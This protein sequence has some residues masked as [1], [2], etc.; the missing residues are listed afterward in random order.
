MRLPDI[1]YNRGVEPLAKQDPNLPRKEAQV[2]IDLS[3]ARLG[4][5]LRSNDEVGAANVRLAKLRREVDREQINTYSNIAISAFNR[6]S[7]KKQAKEALTIGIA[8]QFVQLA[9]QQGAKWYEANE[10]AKVAEGITKYNSGVTNL[11]TKLENSPTISLEDFPG[12]DFSDVPENMIYHGVDAV[13]GKNIRTVPNHVAAPI[14]FASTE[15]SIREAAGEG[16]TGTVSKAQFT[17]GISNRSASAMASVVRS[18]YD[19][20][21]K[22]L[23]GKYKDSYDQAIQQEDIATASDIVDS[24]EA[25]GIWTAE[26]AGKLRS[27][28]LGDVKFSRLVR[29]AD[30]ATTLDQ[31]KAVREE[32][33]DMPKSEQISIRA[34]LSRREN[35]FDAAREKAETAAKR[36]ILA[37]NAELASDIGM[38]AKGGYSD[39]REEVRAWASKNDPENMAH[40]I[41]H[42]TA[43]FNQERNAESAM[44][45]EIT[46]QA[47][48]DIY[49]GRT[50]E[51]PPE[52]TGLNYIKLDELARMKKSGIAPV[53]D[54]KRWQELYT[55]AVRQPEK[56][57][58]LPLWAERGS[59]DSGSFEQLVKMQNSITD[60]TF[61]KTQTIAAKAQFDSMAKQAWGPRYSSSSSGIRK[62]SEVEQ[63]YVNAV[64]QFEDDNNRK[65]TS[66]ERQTILNDLFE[67][68]VKV[69]YKSTFSGI[70]EGDPEP[71]ISSDM[72]PYIRSISALLNARNVPVTSRNIAAQYNK[73]IKDGTLEEL[74]W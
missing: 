60:G 44:V 51:I 36:T 7:E 47:A 68:K 16:I 71:I 29:Q 32:A 70:R 5:E 27:S 4:A 6:K 37:R 10:E 74:D 55:M 17:N 28:L 45:T 40:H 54:L 73:M 3:K 20:E 53:T 69:F 43:R 35:E 31:L 8:A 1:N 2:E 38:S 46:N 9:V 61:N 65:S 11:V 48:E 63:A 39:K 64:D 19:Y 67:S 25:R 72:G 34:I 22:F 33:Y 30:S 58:E 23:S 18:K 12:V 62:A 52:V 41:S 49:T 26:A 42:F 59:L 50:T 57:T 13:T 14:V 24:A 21:N 66:A 15:K 56:F